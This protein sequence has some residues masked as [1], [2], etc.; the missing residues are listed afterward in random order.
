MKIHKCAFCGA[1]IPP[2][3]GIMYVRTDGTVVRYC[4]RKCFVSATRFKRN[5]RKLA[6]VRKQQKRQ[7]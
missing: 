1:D 2:G 4:S 5:P 7:S 6:W 3:Y